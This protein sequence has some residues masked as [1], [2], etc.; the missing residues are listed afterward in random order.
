MA[1]EIEVVELSPQP[2]LV[3]EADVAPPEVGDTLARMLPAVHKY[4]AELSGQMAGMPFMRYLNMAD[5]RFQIDAGIP[6]NTTLPGTEQILS[7]ELPSGRA[8][9]TLF[10]GAY[11]QVGEAWDAIYA[12]C[13]DQNIDAGF[14]G[15]DVY[16]ND[17]TTVS[18]PAELRT[19]LYLPLP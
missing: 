14:G 6:T 11:H 13:A 8:A 10:L 2:V 16:E 18:D 5:G 17:P 3:M 4:L 19:R 12:W 1:Y 9:T 15:C 7:K